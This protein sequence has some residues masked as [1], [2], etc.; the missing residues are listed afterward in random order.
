MK[1][2]LR[3]VGPDDLAIFFEHQQDREATRM[4]AFPAREWDDFLT[5]WRE[6]I[7]ANV[8]A[9]KQAIVVDD[10][11]AGNIL[12]WEQD[13]R[14]LVGYW[15]GRCYWGRGVATVALAK[16]LEHEKTRP[17]FAYVAAHNAGS[18]RVLEKNGFLHVALE[19]RPGTAVD[20][21]LM[22]RLD[23]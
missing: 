19:H 16:Y 12:S 11:V 1:I 15:L 5:H 6:K 3:E 10:K 22:L 4:A 13:G 8:H 14:R 21:E 9:K 7:L 20:D 18:I 2:F 23:R 17:L